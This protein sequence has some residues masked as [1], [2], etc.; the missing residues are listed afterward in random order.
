MIEIVDLIHVNVE[1]KLRLFSYENHKL[2]TKE[3]NL[4]CEDYHRSIFVLEVLVDEMYCVNHY[5]LH[6]LVLYELQPK[7]EINIE[8]NES[9]EFYSTFR[10]DMILI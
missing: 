2:S 4:S 9:E 10:F 3:K 7:I 8:R 5:H 6:R 1:D